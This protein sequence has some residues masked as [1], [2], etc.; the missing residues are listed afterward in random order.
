VLK[1][2][3]NDKRVMEHGVKM[4]QKKEKTGGLILAPQ[5]TLKKTADIPPSRIP[6]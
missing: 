5:N 6:E 2:A 3:V 4:I 1:K